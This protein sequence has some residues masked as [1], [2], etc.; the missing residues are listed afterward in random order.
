[1]GMTFLVGVDGGGSGCRA[2]IATRD[3][4]L[5]VAE[6]GP[7]NVSSDA[8]G[9]VRN[10]LQAVEAAGL[11]AGISLSETVA[12]IGLA[13]VMSRDDA[14]WVAAKMPFARVAVSDDRPT[15]VSGAL[16]SANGFV[17]AIGTGSFIAGK[18]A[19]EF[20]F[21]GGWGAAVS[22][23]ASGAWLGRGALE[24][25]LLCFDGL[26]V[27]SQMTRE[28]LKQFGDDPNAIVSFSQRA[29]PSDLAEYAPLVVEAAR[30][31]DPHGLS[32]MM[33]GADYL[34]RGLQA[35]GFEGGSV[36]LTGGLGL[37][38]TSYLKG[39]EVTAARGS[40]LDGALAL[41]GELA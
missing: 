4:V 22:D 5:A 26:E 33:H 9:A 17:A 29:R 39:V 38:Y 1:M 2:A 35:V 31:D 27:Y 23:Q 20:R 21:V 24:R 8:D 41:A 37:R 25:A 12:H 16:G 6:S 19:D 10:V 36:C 3:G 28:I 15:T 18:T 13:G 34:Q 40:A 30:H 7:A 32:L 14:A 11:Q